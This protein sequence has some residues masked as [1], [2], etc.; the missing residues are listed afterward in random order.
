[1]NAAAPPTRRA[2]Y[3]AMPKLAAELLWAPVADAAAE[4][5]LTDV[6]G[7]WVLGLGSPS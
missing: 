2:A 7:G 6:G 3:I 4:E 5:V 1:M